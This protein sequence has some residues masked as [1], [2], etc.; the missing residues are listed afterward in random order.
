[1]LKK[2][3]LIENIGN[4]LKELM[5]EKN[6]TTIAELA[7]K[8]KLSKDTLQGYLNTRNSSLPDLD[9][10]IVLARFFKVSLS[11]LIGETDI[12][13]ADNIFICEKLGIN[14]KTIEN[15]EKIKKINQKYNNDYFGLIND[16]IINPSLYNR[17]IENTEIL[18]NEDLHKNIQEVIEKN[19]N[20]VIGK[21]SLEY[22]D[23]V[24]ILISQKFLE[25]YNNYIILRTPVNVGK[26]ELEQEIY[27]LKKQLKI[28]E[29]K[30]KNKYI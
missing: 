10:I 17:I 7:K 14:D 16:V 12:R 30:Y 15:L 11:Y 20:R 21:N 3:I 9:K 27:N 4:R 28:A 23:F 2:E 25:L 19:S 5:K 13:N 6:I 24:N 26:L 22:D 8:T 1:M 18:L 29:K